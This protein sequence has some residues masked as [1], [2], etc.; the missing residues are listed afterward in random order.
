MTVQSLDNLLHLMPQNDKPAL[1]TPENQ[2]LTFA[3][4]HQRIGHFAGALHKKGIQPGD[5]VLILIPM[6][7]ELYVALLGT[8]WIGAT[9]MLVDPSAPLEK[10][11]PRFQPHAFIGSAKAHLLRLKYASLR[12]CKLYLSTSFTILWHQNMHKCHDSIP[13]IAIPE[14]PALLTFTTGTTGTPKAMARSHQFLLCQHQALAHHMHYEPQDVDL[15]TLPVFLLHSLAAGAT[16]ILADADLKAVGSVNGS[17][18]ISQ[19]QQ[20]R[21]T[22]LSASPAFF[23]RLIEDCEKSAIT[24]D[25]ITQIFTGGAR[26]NAKTV[27][28]LQQYFP[29]A[30]IHIVY[31]STEAEPIA[32]CPIH[33]MMDDFIDGEASGKGALVGYPVPEIQVLIQEHEIWVTGAHVNQQYYQDPQSD[34]QNKVCIDG[35]IWHRTGDAGYFDSQGRLWLL[36]RIG[37]DINGDWPLPIEGQAEFLQFVK[38]A[39]LIQWK[40]QGILVVEAMQNLDDSQIAILKNLYPRLIFMKKI[41]V[42]PR[43]NAKINRHQLLQILQ[44]TPQKMY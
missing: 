13:P 16:C 19:I 12:K 24:L 25:G 42:D 32:V 31:G 38:K 21:V 7:I 3:E 17:K 4:L 5:R 40:N 41:P 37:D 8:L 20:H 27:Q 10:I 18:I 1:I 39:A 36:G 9:V 43:H 26:V 22:S 11:L 35:V 30:K 44:N 34:A 14:H 33:D 6:S 2:T 29:Y 15:P 28:G 23:Q